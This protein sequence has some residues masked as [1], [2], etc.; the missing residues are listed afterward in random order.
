[1]NS[2]GFT[3]KQILV[4]ITVWLT[5]LLSFV[6]RLSWSTLMPIV[7]DAMNFTV[8]Q[9][10]T[11]VTAFYFGYALMVLPG[12]MLADR[13]GY[14]KTILFSLLA[15]SIITGFMSMITSYT[16]GL[17]LR[18][19]LGIVSGP[20]Q[21]SCLSA[22]G[23]YFSSKQRGTAVGIFITCTSFGIS[24]IN[25]YAPYVATHY[26]WR[27]AFAVTAVLPLIVML[28][29]FFT[30]KPIRDKISIE[31]DIKNNKSEPGINTSLKANLKYLICNK[32]IILMSITGFF[33]TGATWGVTNWTNLY[34]V[35]N[36]GVTPIFAGTIMT[37]Y[38]LAALI[39]KPTIG[40]LSDILPIQ[41]SHLA[42]LCLFLFAPALII[43]ANTSQ[44]NMLYITGAILGIGAFMYS[45][46][47]NALVINAAPD[48]LRATTAGFVNLFNQAG[49]LSAPMLLGGILS[50]TGN[51]QTAL[52]V[53]AIFPIIGSIALYLVKIK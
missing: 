25:L 28:L 50:A 27:V 53:I 48:H 5:F 9:G 32:N 17:V 34:M 49:S 42:S 44:A 43:F 4:L 40:F 31:S 16:M 47:T 12:G 2:K 21:S 30:V 18:F 10:T 39:S 6:T 22:I 1:M 13:F 52:L 45:A 41:K 8:T 46:L 36:L 35:K 15:M 3:K 24:T 19:L 26:G 33:A 14:R 20:V 7:N 29:S 51:Y 37:I 38:G 11:Y 23:D